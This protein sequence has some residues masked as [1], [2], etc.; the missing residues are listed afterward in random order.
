LHLG[1]FGT[2]GRKVRLVHWA[3]A[4]GRIRYRGFK[5]E[6]A[7]LIR[8]L[9]TNKS[10]GATTR[11]LDGR[12]CDISMKNR[13]KPKTSH[14]VRHFIKAPQTIVRSDDQHCSRINFAGLGLDPHEAIDRIARSSPG[15]ENPDAQCSGQPGPPAAGRCSGVTTSRHSAA[16]LPQHGYTWT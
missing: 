14:I 15:P 4:E 9:K 16:L 12:L 2:I 5:P 1:I 6:P 8:R 7:E 11:H 13:K 10:S 3:L